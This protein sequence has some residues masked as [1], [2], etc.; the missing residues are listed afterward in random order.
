[1]VLIVPSYH[2]SPGGV[3]YIYI[4]IYKV[5]TFNRKSFFP[6]FPFSFPMIH[7]TF[8]FASSSSSQGTPSNRLFFFSQTCLPSFLRLILL[9]DF[10][11]LTNLPQAMLKAADTVRCVPSLTVVFSNVGLL[12]LV[13]IPKLF[14]KN[15]SAVA[16]P[17]NHACAPLL[18]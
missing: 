10:L 12:L 3:L 11:E 1:M 7:T 18:F 17:F 2:T 9:H 16:N 14:K 4:Y 8:R 15:I 5:L 13:S 6:S